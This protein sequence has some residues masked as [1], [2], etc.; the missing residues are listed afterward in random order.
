ML[1]FVNRKGL[2]MSILP[3]RTWRYQVEGF[4]VMPLWLAQYPVASLG[5]RCHWQLLMHNSDGYPVELMLMLAFR[6]YGMHSP[7]HGRVGIS[8][9]IVTARGRSASSL[10]RFHE[11]ER[12]TAS[13]C[14]AS[15]MPASS[16]S[17]KKRGWCVTWITWA[18][19]T[20]LMLQSFNNH[21][22]G[23]DKNMSENRSPYNRPPSLI[24]GP[25]IFF[26]F[27]TSQQV[28]TCELI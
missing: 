8:F 21:N 10:E 5:V 2:Y 26:Y 18:V 22:N 12:D 17:D 15:G 14:H 3:F 16:P 24:Q 6:D 7:Q 20:G 1:P 23:G 28:Q 27:K 25:V 19:I 11:S 4:F 9:H 13:P